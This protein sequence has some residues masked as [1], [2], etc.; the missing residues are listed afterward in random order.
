MASFETV[1]V[2]AIQATPVILNAE[3]TV[4]KACELLGDAAADGAQ[5]AVLPETFVAVYPGNDWAH[6]AGSFAGWDELWER[7]WASSVD[8]PGPLT[9]RLADRCRE[10]GIHCAI[11]VNERESERPGSLYN[12]LL[13]IGPDGLLHKHRKLMP[14]M[15]ERL[16]HGIGAGDDLDVTETPLGRIGGLICWENRM[17]LARYA[18]YRGG[19][20][21]WIAPTADDTDSWIASMRHIA[22]E[23]GAFVVSA[24]QY[25][26]AAA[27]PDDFPVPLPDDADIFGRGG[28]AIC[29]PDNGEV[30]AGP[31]YGEEGIVAADC[32]LRLGLRAKRWFD[33][34][35]HYSREDLLLPK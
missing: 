33:A 13:L 35:G 25:I 10:L 14:T 21:I 27:F 1:R 20:Q 31:L 2:A 18:V 16:F 26:P 12:A 23:S 15:Q 11:G 9:D 5:L 6:D 28:A 4:D 29:E 30:I 24:P 22:I 8:V 7:L 19:P 32:D 34:A 17:P 3:A